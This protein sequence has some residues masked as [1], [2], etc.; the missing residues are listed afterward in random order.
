VKGSIVKL[1]NIAARNVTLAAFLA[2]SGA[3][4]AVSAVAADNSPAMK[5]SP[6][7]KAEMEKHRQEMFK[8]MSDRMA[9]RLEIKPSQQGAFQAYTSALQTAV[10]PP[11]NHSEYKSDAAS[12]ARMN[13]DMAAEHAK[14]LATIA[15]A[16]AKFQE[17]LSP[18][19]RKTF[20]QMAAAFMHHHHGF[21][22]EHGWGHDRGYDGHEGQEG[23]DGH[24]GWGRDGGW[25]HH[26]DGAQH[27]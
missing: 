20:D 10:T 18:D 13:A 19:Q 6:E 8:H 21:G 27:N 1:F 14:R 5:V 25:E 16:T 4:L 7:R 12:I 9:E 22:H 15:D 24:H 26:Q 11:A 17:V 23:Q 2:V 3:A